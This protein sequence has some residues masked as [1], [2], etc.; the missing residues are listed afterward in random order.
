MIY[1][2]GGMLLSRNRC[3]LKRCRKCHK[4][5]GNF[6]Q[7]FLHIVMCWGKWSTGQR[8]VTENSEKLSK[9]FILK[10]NDSLII[11]LGHLSNTGS[12][13]GTYWGNAHSS[14]LE[15][16]CSKSY[17]VQYTFLEKQQTHQVFAALKLSDTGISAL[18]QFCLAYS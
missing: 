8:K 13:D 7:F 1:Y 6:F 4:I 12:K 15:G 11:K 18:L 5:Y 9:Q 17:M 16:K 3:S 2:L 10:R 14:G